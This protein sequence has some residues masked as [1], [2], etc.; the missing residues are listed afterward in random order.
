M[1]EIVLIVLVYLALATIVLHAPL[2]VMAR[3][4]GLP[5]PWVAFIPIANVW[6]LTSL[7]EGQDDY[8]H[9]ISALVLIGLLLPFINLVV[10]A[11]VWGNL[12]ESMGQSRYLGWLIIV[13][14]LNVAI[15]WV[16]ASRANPDGRRQPER[17][18]PTR[19]SR[20]Q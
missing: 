19:A 2:Y 18:S 9:G 12:A 14:F 5:A 10:G 7:S 20:L 16:I 3:K 4:I 17:I 1:S 8:D 13:P 11:A 6:V 15:P